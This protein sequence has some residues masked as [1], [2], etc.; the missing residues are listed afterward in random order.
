MEK[1]STE[2]LLFANPLLPH[3][4][5]PAFILPPCACTGHAAYPY[6]GEVSRRLHGQRSPSDLH[7]Q[8][9]ATQNT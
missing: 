9:M 3:Y 4:K 7:L 6:V 2:Q 5:V 8:R 1:K